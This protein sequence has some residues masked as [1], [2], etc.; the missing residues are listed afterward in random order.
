MRTLSGM[1]LSGRVSIEEY[2]DLDLTEDPKNTRAWLNRHA[3]RKPK[4]DDQPQEQAVEETPTT[5]SGEDTDEPV[6]ETPS[7]PDV[8]VIIDDT[9]GPYDQEDEVEVALIDQPEDGVEETPPVAD[10][11]QGGQTTEPSGDDQLLAQL[12]ELLREI[13]LGLESDR[14]GLERDVAGVAELEE[15]GFRA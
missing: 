6:E 1:L 3:P 4:A 2:V 12:E 5:A 15:M 11:D 9:P 14:A 13:N 8:V 7:A 10:D